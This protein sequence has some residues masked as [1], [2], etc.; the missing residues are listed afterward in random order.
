MIYVLAGTNS[1]QIQ[2]QLRALREEFITKYGREGVE[3]YAGENLEPSE[4]PNLF[5]SASL[6][7][8]HRLVIIKQLSEN[9][10]AA[11]Q[12]IALIKTTPDE[13]TVVLTEGGL[14]KR[15]AYYKALKKLEYFHEYGELEE[16]TLAQ[17]VKETVA[18]AQA[19]ID[20]TAVQ[21]LLSAAGT[22]QQ[23]LSNEVA[24]L[25][26]YSKDITV[27]TVRLLVEQ[28]P[29]D[30]VFDL[31]EAALGDKQSRALQL[32]DQLERAHEDPF[33][34]VNML[35]WQVHILA[36]VASAEDMPDGDV[37]RNM[38]FNPYVVSKTR[39]L[40]KRINR[41][42]LQ[43]IIDQTAKLDIRLKTGTAEPWRLL[44]QTIIA[45]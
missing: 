20:E 38:K 9:K 24:K 45:L 26:A 42:Q 12:F 15:T 34:L 25:A 10:A 17:W 33:Q 11:E 3:V 22:D 5:S 16:R 8:S 36:V 4:L 23:R 6:F 32:L 44:E 21:V 41:R 13:T 30:S 14:D 43:K 28:N 29:R 27:E 18:A 19:T 40:A 7:T 31:L 35:I 39:R 37:A 2:Q 1:F